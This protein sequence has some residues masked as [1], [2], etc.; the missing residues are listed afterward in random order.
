MAFDPNAP[1]Q[2]LFAYQPAPPKP[3]EPQV[4]Y[5]PNGI[6]R[7][8]GFYNPDNPYDTGRHG[9]SNRELN[10]GKGGKVDWWDYDKGQP[11]S[12]ATLD[13]NGMWTL[14]G[15]GGGLSSTPSAPGVGAVGSAFGSNPYLAGVNLAAG[16]LG[17]KGFTP[18]A[19]APIASDSIQALAAPQ[20]GSAMPQI[21]GDLGAPQYT[22]ALSLAALQNLLGHAMRPG[23][24][25]AI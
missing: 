6:A 3:A 10:N 14:G 5:T 11:K 9:E 8:P 18:N 16:L 7:Q 25:N 24:R 19:Q 20:L 12:G 17:I 23:P 1:L 21:P 15:G 22:G 4:T 2:G 13:G